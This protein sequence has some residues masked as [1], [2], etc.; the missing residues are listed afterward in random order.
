MRLART[1]AP[2]PR[3]ALSRE[4]RS[5]RQDSN[6]RSPTPEVGGVADLPYDQSVPSSP[7]GL[8][9]ATRG[10]EA[11][12]SSA[13]LRGDRRPWNRTTLDRHIRAAPAQSACRRCCSQRDGRC[14]IDDR[15]DR[16]T[17]RRRVSERRAS[18]SRPR[19]RARAI[20]PGGFEPPSPTLAR[21]RSDPLS[22]DESSALDGSRTRLTRETAKP[23]H[24]ARPRACVCAR[25]H[26]HRTERQLRP[27]QG[28]PSGILAI[29]N[30]GSG[31][32]SAEGGGAPG[33]RTPLG[34]MQA[35][36]LA[37]K[38]PMRER[39]PGLEPGPQRWQRRVLPTLTPRSHRERPERG[40]NPR[41]RC[42]RPGSWP[43][44]RPGR[45]PASIAPAEPS[46]DGRNRTLSGGV[47]DRMDA[48]SSSVRP[49]SSGGIRTTHPSVQSRRS[50][51]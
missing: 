19:S 10:V 17:L 4:R 32:R 15:R 44:R 30:R 31:S 50:C 22:Y 34:W 1:A 18:P 26:E 5:G 49:S 36:I 39:P 20:S 42:E 47:G 38:S 33:N 9:P 48:M 46:T 27:R 8:E 25:E 29:E 35:T 6:L 13:E 3:V 45:V 43:T 40:S 7:A 23:H 21:W 37:T 12:C 51:R 14:G 2:L 41:H 11:L 28:T 16:T 24:Q